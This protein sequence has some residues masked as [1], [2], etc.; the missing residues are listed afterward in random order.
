MKNSESELQERLFWLIRLRWVAVLGVIGVLGFTDSYLH[1]NLPYITLGLLIAV[2]ALCNL[3]FYWLT[4]FLMRSTLSP[5]AGLDKIANLHSFFA[6]YKKE[7]PALWKKFNCGK[8][9]KIWFEKEVLK[10]AR[11]HWKHP[12]LDELERLIKKL[13]QTTE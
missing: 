6:Q 8:E 12:M 10:M 13:E 4:N 5:S 2:L 11:K 1:F 9:K 7:G 3:L